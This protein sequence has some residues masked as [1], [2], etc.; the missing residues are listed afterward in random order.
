MSIL[1]NFDGFKKNKNCSPY[2][3]TYSI[4]IN[5]NEL[6]TIFKKQNIDL[7]VIY[8]AEVN[9]IEIGKSKI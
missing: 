9:Q 1:N 2:K 5:F 6:N 3:Y 4:W 7:F 8:C